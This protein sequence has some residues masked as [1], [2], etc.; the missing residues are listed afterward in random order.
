MAAAQEEI[1]KIRQAEA[2]AREKIST[3]KERAL[4]IRKQ[5]EKDANNI[6]EGSRKEV[7]KTA[8]K[9]KEEKMVALRKD[10]EEAEKRIKTQIEQLELK[11]HEMRDQAIKYIFEHIIGEAQSGE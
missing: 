7:E 2:E 4:Q 5:A 9:L 11:A 3:A 10:E 6:L 1:K 8:L